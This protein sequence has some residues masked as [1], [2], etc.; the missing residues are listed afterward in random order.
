M[1]RKNHTHTFSRKQ[2]K[3]KYEEPHHKLFLLV[4]DGADINRKILTIIFFKFLI[5]LIILPLICS[6]FYYL[7]KKSVNGTEII[8][9]PVTFLVISKLVEEAVVL[10]RVLLRDDPV[11]G[12]PWHRLLLF[13]GPAA[14]GSHAEYS[15][16]DHPQKR[17]T[18]KC[19]CGARTGVAVP[20]G[21]GT[22]VGN[23]HDTRA[24]DTAYAA[25]SR[26]CARELLIIECR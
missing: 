21:D 18:Q 26:R 6:L 9:Y 20:G 11:E 1:L 8:I 13:L 15:R 5:T 24:F 7:I 2:I 12:G 10:V 19:K 4:L 17:S 3:K 25:G 23:L 14:D 16:V 22:A